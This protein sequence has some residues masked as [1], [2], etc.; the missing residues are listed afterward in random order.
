[1]EP[2]TLYI[3][4]LLLRIAIIGKMYFVS[5]RYQLVQIIYISSLQDHSTCEAR[6]WVIMLLREIF[7]L[8]ILS[9]KFRKLMQ[10]ICIGRCYTG[11]CP[12]TIYIDQCP[13]YQYKSLFITGTHNPFWHMIIQ[14]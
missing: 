7:L 5:E 11:N 6:S 3:T 8:G 10:S 14:F 9:F 12:N 1:M 4:I 13:D 2:N